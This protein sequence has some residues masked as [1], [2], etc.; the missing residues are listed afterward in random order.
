[1][2]FVPRGSGSGS[3]AHG[4]GGADGG[5]GYSD[6]DGRVEQKRSKSKIERFGAGLEKGQDEEEDDAENGRGGRTQRRHA[7]RSASKNT[8]RRK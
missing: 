3:R 1:M 8:F 6:E 5:D 7:G 2:S 4:A